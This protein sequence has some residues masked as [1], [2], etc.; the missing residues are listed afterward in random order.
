MAAALQVKLA[1]LE[2]MKVKLADLEQQ[3]VREESMKK[4]RGA[5]SGLKFGGRASRVDLDTWTSAARDGIVGL[6]PREAAGF[7][8]AH[9]E[10]DAREEVMLLPSARRNDAEHILNHLTKLYSTNGID[11]RSI[12]IL[13]LRRRQQKMLEVHDAI[14]AKLDTQPRALVSDGRRVVGGR[15]G[16]QQPPDAGHAAER[17]CYRCNARGHVARFCWKGRRYRRCFK[18][19]EVG[20]VRRDCPR[21]GRATTQ[22][23]DAAAPTNSDGPVDERLEPL[24]QQLEEA[25]QREAKLQS[26]AK[27]IAEQ[28]E[29]SRQEAAER[30]LGF[31]QAVT[32][33]KAE[34][35]EEVVGLQGEADTLRTQVIML[36]AD[37]LRWHSESDHDDD[38]QQQ[39]DD[40]TESLDDACNERDTLKDEL[41]KGSRKLKKRSTASRDTAKLEESCEALRQEVEEL[42]KETRA[43]EPLKEQL[44]VVRKQLKAA[45]SRV[46]ELVKDSSA[47]RRRDSTSG[48]EDDVSSCSERGDKPVAASRCPPW[49]RRGQLGGVCV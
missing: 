27:Q 46:E 5:L 11:A 4:A 19:L 38:L 2:A 17:R 41:E 10:D 18:C 25:R 32:D 14:M 49:T 3:L 39:V 29:A 15:D 23:D 33:M 34:H 43:I 6:T 7:L 9:V 12:D 22:P 47:R 42:Q 30:A 45:R 44:R 26:D 24:R 31:D 37:A 35:V 1:E 8:V 13:E 40:L 48:Y 36:K 16:R 20:H 28:L 21:I